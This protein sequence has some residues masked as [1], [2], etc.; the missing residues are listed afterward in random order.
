[1]KTGD[2]R[3]VGVLFISQKRNFH[4]KKTEVSKDTV[5]SIDADRHYVTIGS[6]QDGNDLG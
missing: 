5:T 4:V 6:C 3:N 1:M 2:E